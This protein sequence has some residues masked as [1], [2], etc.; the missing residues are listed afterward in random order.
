[1]AIFNSYVSLPEGNQEEKVKSYG[2]IVEKSGKLPFR[3]S[4]FYLF[5]VTLKKTDYPRIWALDGG[6]AT[7]VFRCK[8]NAHSLSD[9]TNAVNPGSHKPSPTFTIMGAT[10]CFFPHPQ[11][12]GLWHWLSQGG[13]HF[14]GLIIHNWELILRMTVSVGWIPPKLRWIDA[15]TVTCPYVHIYN[16]CLFIYNY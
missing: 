12:V 4:F 10:M 3:L 1:M 6:Q 13:S 7:V 2:R 16:I 15:V 11:M 14:L 9:A 5:W 8:P